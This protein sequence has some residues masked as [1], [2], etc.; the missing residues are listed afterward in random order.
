MTQEAPLPRKKG[1][2]TH[3]VPRDIFWNHDPLDGRF[4]DPPPLS[5]D[6]FLSP[7][8]PQVLSSPTSPVTPASALLQRSPGFCGY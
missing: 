4:L 7:L 8:P 2:E 3:R 1:L 6:Y 5:W